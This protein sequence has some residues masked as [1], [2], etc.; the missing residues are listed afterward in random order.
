MWPGCRF[1]TVDQALPVLELLRFGRRDLPGPQTLMDARMYT[2]LAGAAARRANHVVA[3]RD[4]ANNFDFLADFFLTKW[5]FPDKCALSNKP[6]ALTV[7]SN[8]G[9]EQCVKVG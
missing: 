6:V 4:A 1:V 9:G 5:V 3:R 2:G 8:H 7:K